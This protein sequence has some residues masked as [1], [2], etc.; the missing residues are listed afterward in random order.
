VHQSWLSRVYIRLLGSLSVGIIGRAK[1]TGVGYW[2]T[3]GLPMF[4]W[5]PAAVQ[6]RE[7]SWHCW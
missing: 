1:C 5:G 2:D 3:Q 6:C 7:D 4:H